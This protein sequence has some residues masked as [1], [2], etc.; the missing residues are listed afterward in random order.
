MFIMI[1]G[2]ENCPFCDKAKALAAS[3]L[4][5]ETFY[6]DMDKNGVTKQDLQRT[7]GKP[8]STVPQ[9]FIDGLHIGGYTEFEAHVS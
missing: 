6:F 4:N 1:Y 8:V 3:L 2:K 7:V 9:V 5:A